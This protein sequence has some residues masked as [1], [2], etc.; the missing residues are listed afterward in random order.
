METI[1][2]KGHKC[3]VFRKYFVTD[4]FY[5]YHLYALMVST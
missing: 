5:K 2:E 4:N 1:P 3:L